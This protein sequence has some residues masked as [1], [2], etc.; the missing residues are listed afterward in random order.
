MVP[1]VVPTQTGVRGFQFTFDQLQARISMSNW[2]EC[3]DVPGVYLIQ[4]FDSTRREFFRYIGMLQRSL[5]D[6][7]KMYA[8]TGGT[9]G[10]LETDDGN[11]YLAQ[12]CT[13]I[14]A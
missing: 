12:L 4:M 2:R 13:R 9:A 11:K 1:S 5:R 7:W 3:L 10:G 8:E 6:R 14:G